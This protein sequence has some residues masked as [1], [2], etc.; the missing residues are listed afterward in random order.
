MRKQ[1]TWRT[2]IIGG[3]AAVSVAAAFIVWSG[4][5][6]QEKPDTGLESSDQQ[7][8]IPGTKAPVLEKEP[9][10]V[11]TKPTQGEKETK[12]EITDRW[13]VDAT[14]EETESPEK[15][16]EPEKV[17]PVIQNPP[18]SEP[19]DETENIPVAGTQI[20]SL[21]FAEGQTLGDR[22]SVV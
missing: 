7:L 12:E 6:T 4:N 21:N 15:E 2:L 20:H 17:P 10:T 5:R 13:E 1:N 22:K 18:V 8:E 11:P 19:K 3:I 9:G 16:E 14:P